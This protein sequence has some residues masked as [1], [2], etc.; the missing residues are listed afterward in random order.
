MRRSMSDDARDGLSFNMIRQIY[1]TCLYLLAKTTGSSIS[2]PKN[3][4]SPALVSA[5]QIYLLR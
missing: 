2:C 3:S 5:A 4:L 1:F